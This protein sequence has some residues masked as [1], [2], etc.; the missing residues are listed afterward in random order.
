MSL[1]VL[2][3]QA[4]TGAW[5]T[6]LGP[7]IRGAKLSGSGNSANPLG[8]VVGCPLMLCQLEIP[9]AYRPID[10]AWDGMRWYGIQWD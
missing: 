6:H 1:G 4:A 2:P 8:A 10:V 9:H 3:Y 7:K 5:T